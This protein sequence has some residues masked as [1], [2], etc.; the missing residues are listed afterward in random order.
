MSQAE[1]QAA[2][3]YCDARFH[4]VPVPDRCK[5]PVI[6][7]WQNLRLGRD[8][9]SNYFDGRSMNIGILLGDDYSITDVDLDCQEAVRAA[10]CYLPDTDMVFGRLTKRASHY[11][12]RMDPPQPSVTYK[13][14]DRKTMLVELRCQKK[15]G[16]VG[17]QTIV[18]PSR[19]ETGEDI[20]FE[21]GCGPSPANVDAET[22]LTAVARVAA[23]TLLARHWPA[24]G[25]GR[26]SAMLALAGGLA[27]CAWSK[28]DTKLFCRAVYQTL[29]NPDPKAMTRSDGEVESTYHQKE[30]ES[31]FTGWPHL[32]RSASK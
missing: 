17:L 5:G 19:H 9:I 2:E 1:A 27:R 24:R 32:I 18:P 10:R 7:G 31:D 21:P 25:K 22:L 15:D 29:P 6:N 28:E 14:T 4:P 12:Y 3:Q 16:T 8:D 20:R 30:Q 13:D 11:I 26:H 23:T